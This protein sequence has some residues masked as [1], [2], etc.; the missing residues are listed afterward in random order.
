MPLQIR[1]AG[2]KDIPLIRELANEIWP[3]T[4]GQLMEKEK[5]D[6]MLQLIYSEQS[7]LQQM[8]KGHEFILV[9]HVDDYVGFASSSMIEPGICKLHK[10]YVLPSE[11]GKGTGR[12]I[13]DFIIVRIK[14]QGAKALRLNV[15]RDNPAKTFYKRM[16]FAVIGEEDIDIGGGYFMED[17]VMERSLLVE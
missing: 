16:G 17:W 7:L 12:F 2:P 10:I 14:A 5:L 1:Q 11:Q 3:V 4:Y 9:S 6:Y 8:E 15:K 13:I